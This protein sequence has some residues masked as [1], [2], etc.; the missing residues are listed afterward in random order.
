MKTYNMRT[1]Y[2]IIATQTLSLIG[3]RISG[4]A[5]GIWIF[6]QTGDVTPLA[7]VA[8]FSMVPQVLLSNVAGVLADRWDRRLL[9]AIS[10]MGQAV[11]TILL[12]VLFATGNFELWQLYLVVAI[13]ALF[14]VF[15][16]P[17]FDASVTML[18]PEEQRDRANGIRQ[19]TN[20]VAGIIAPAIAGVVFAFF[21][22]IGAIVID[23]ATFVVAFS[24]ILMVSIPKP[25]KTE[26]GA[27]LSGSFWQEMFGG[28]RFLWDRPVL[29][30][31]VMCVMLVNFLFSIAGILFTPYI[32]A[33]TGSETAYGMIQSLFNAGMLIGGIIISIWGGT[34]PRIH[35]IMPSLIV[36]GIFITIMGMTR[37]TTSLAIIA[38]VALLPNAF[39]N[40]LFMSM[41]QSKVAPDVQ[42][43]VFAVIGQLAMLMTPIALL[44]AGSL[45]DNVFEPL[46][47][48]PI[49][50]NFAPFFGSEAGAGMGMMIAI[51]GMI[52]ALEGILMYAHP[53]VRHMETILPDYEAHPAEDEIEPELAVA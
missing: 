22:V 35:T 44:M 4:L 6:Q 10:D 31:V 7:L 37:T 17:A 30:W 3:S 28:F 21:G 25:R 38:F 40:V 26:D 12:L 29:F 20:P 5:F 18:V 24:V 36:M 16:Q 2:T 34:R 13:Q 50:A 43:R 14:G 51:V 53:A 23:L 42:G 27:K 41:M 1:F 47:N 11:G 45:A 32:L 9:M 48:Q 49:W 15:Q 46:V 8:F 39:G 52:V 19:M 33:R